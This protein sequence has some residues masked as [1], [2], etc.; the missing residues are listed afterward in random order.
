[1]QWVLR[2]SWVQFQV[3]QG[4]LG[5][6]DGRGYCGSDH[7]RDD[8]LAGMVGGSGADGVRGLV[9]EIG[10]SAEFSR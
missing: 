8:F 4:C 10:P 7:V 2:P 3:S 5:R 1:M 9:G 6:G